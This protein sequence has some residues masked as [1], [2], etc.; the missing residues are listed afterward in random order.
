MAKSTGHKKSGGRRKGIPN[1]KTQALQERADAL[2]VDPFTILLLFAAGDWR[3][4]GYKKATYWKAVGQY[5]GYNEDRIPAELRA[6]CAADA[7][8]YLH[9]KR[10]AIEVTGRDGGPLEVYLRMTPEERATR[11]KALEERLK[12]G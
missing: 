10:K 9:P 8:Q 4:L 12:R 3:G 6:K 7:C 1:R 11:R 2:R 5:G